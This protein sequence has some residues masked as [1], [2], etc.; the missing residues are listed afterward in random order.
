MKA[1]DCSALLRGFL[2]GTF[3]ALALAFI[4]GSTFAYLTLNSAS[5]V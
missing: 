3:P 4:I 1:A 5:R 2:A